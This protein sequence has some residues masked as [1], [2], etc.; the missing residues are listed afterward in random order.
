M[1]DFA[2]E[3]SKTALVLID[4]QNDFLHP[5]GAYSRSGTSTPAIVALPARLHPVATAMRAAG[6]FVVSTHFTLVPGK[7]GIPLI[8]DHLRRL[9]P[10]L[11]M[12]DFQP[13]AFGHQLVDALKPAD[14]T[15]EKV[16]FSAFYESRLEFVLRMADIETLIFAG[17]VT[18]GGIARFPLRRVE[19]R[20]CSFFRR[21]SSSRSRVDQ[22]FGNAADLR[23]ADR[24]ADPQMSLFPAADKRFDVAIP[25]A[26]VG[27][28]AC[29]LTA[30]LAAHDVGAEVV[31]FERDALPRG[32]T[33]LSSGFIPAAGTRYQ[34]ARGIADSPALLLSDI[35]HKSHGQSDPVIAD[36]VSHESGPT[37]EWLA[38]R[39]GLEFVLV[40]GFLYPGHSVLRMHAHPR[41]TGEALM[42]AL[43]DAANRVG[44]DIITEAH[45]VDLYADVDGRVRGLACLR[46]GGGHEEAA[47]RLDHPWRFE[48]DWRA[49]SR[50]TRRASVFPTN[51]SV[52]RSRRW[53]CWRSPAALP[54]VSMTH[55][56]THWA[57]ISRIIAMPR[58]R[59]LSAARTMSAAWRQLP[60]SRG[61]CCRIPSR[62]WRAITAAMP[63]RS[64]AISA[65]SQR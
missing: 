30:A 13:G 62:Q 23:P 31:V 34:R 52:I 11:T 33:A 6:G 63:I 55:A 42:G 48:L 35:Q 12:G 2:F 9:R 22:H 60:M 32:S 14:F 24:F 7:D 61:R 41:R 8:S 4:L 51:I 39:H 16:A 19:R 27:A 38:D 28:G 17:I 50:S 53:P 36:I 1:S 56:S 20:L 26:I 47:T 15:V 37:I 64:A 18:N 57:A 65:A 3:A 21:G 46:P 29:G 58:R 25:V 44:I 59:A 43:L 5:Q 45:V 49:G 10:F 40:D 54:G